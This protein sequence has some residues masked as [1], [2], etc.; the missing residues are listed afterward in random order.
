[1]HFF[2]I[3]DISQKDFLSILLAT[4]PLSFIAGNL[5]INLNII[6]FILFSLIFF[7]QDVFK[8]N[9][10]F[11]DK[12]IFI[13]FLFIIFTSFYNYFF[14]DLDGVYRLLSNPIKSILFLKYFLLYITLRFLIEKNLI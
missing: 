7:R 1:M 9:Y 10:Y 4:L 11:I 6:L 5:I 12:I 8:I 2:S 14:Y 13:Y 3:K